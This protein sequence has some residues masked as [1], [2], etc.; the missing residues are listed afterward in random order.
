MMSE[1]ERQR[2][3]QAIGW[4]IRLRDNAAVADWIAFTAWLEADP[5]N[6]A[7]YD[8]L[9]AVDWF[10]R[11]GDVSPA[12]SETPIAINDD[13]PVRYRPRFGWTLSAASLAAAAVAG[14]AI[15]A[16]HSNP[17]TLATR[18]GEQRTFTLG[19][20]TRLALNGGTVL[21]I[22]PRHPRQALLESGEAVFTVLHD[23]D[24][25]FEVTVGNTTVRDLGTVFDVAHEA[26]Q[27]RI[28]VASGR[29]V[30]TTD[31]DPVTLDRGQ[32]L[33]MRGDLIERASIAPSDVGGWRIGRL[34]FHQ[35]P[36]GQVALE[37]SRTTGVP[38][39]LDSAL[40]TRSYTG[41]L[42]IDHDREALFR[43]LGPLL[44]VVST[45]DAGGWHW[46]PPR[47]R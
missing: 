11:Q 8:R 12:A 24:H 9:A 27:T 46:A 31:G 37:V 4:L 28:A 39:S 10:G 36:L 15:W 26:D 42:I 43:R 22:A 41:L 29:V 25:P 30:A 18:A 35:A 47:T 5:A 23:A 3:E 14:V 17:L 40:A 16:P 13:E 32:E 21:T 44:G 38:I 2:E 33:V 19:D 20:G 7:T 45:R 1:T 34:I 6:N